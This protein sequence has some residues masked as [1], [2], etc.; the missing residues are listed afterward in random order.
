ML[1]DI[2][3]A[4]CG[5]GATPTPEF[6]CCCWAVPGEGGRVCG[7]LGRLFVAL[8]P[9]MG[10][11]GRLPEARA[12]GAV[13]GLLRTPPGLLPSAPAPSRS[14]FARTGPPERKA[15]MPGP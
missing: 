3:Y 4:G 10:E 1:E 11:A 8:P 2:G 12:D 15:P 9:P 6:R 14:A 5:T 7:E 13:A